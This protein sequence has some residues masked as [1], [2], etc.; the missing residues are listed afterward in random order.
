MSFLFLFFFFFFFWS[1]VIQ[2]DEC[3]IN[4]SGSSERDFALRYLVHFMGDL[5]MPLHLVGRDRGGNKG[6]MEIQR[7]WRSVQ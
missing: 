2:E 1:V 7:R 4:Y 5:H 6:D 3:L